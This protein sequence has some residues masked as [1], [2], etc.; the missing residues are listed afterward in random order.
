MAAFQM[1]IFLFI[2]RFLQNQFGKLCNLQH[3]SHK[4]ILF[5]KE[6]RGT[7]RHHINFKDF[8]REDVH[9]SAKRLP[10]Q[11]YPQRLRVRASNL[12]QESLLDPQVHITDL[13]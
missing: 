5:P 13:D 8:V 2:F 1:H 9:L 6:D 4:R 12:L 11:P 10:C 3:R 7:A